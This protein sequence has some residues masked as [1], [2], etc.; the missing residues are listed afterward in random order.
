MVGKALHCS[1]LFL[2]A[3]RFQTNDATTAFLVLVFVHTVALKT[4]DIAFAQPNPMTVKLAARPLSGMVLELAGGRERGI[5]RGEGIVPCLQS[6]NGLIL[7]SEGKWQ[8]V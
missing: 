2:Q 3:S 4:N 7:F 5:H 1:G 8:V 6:L